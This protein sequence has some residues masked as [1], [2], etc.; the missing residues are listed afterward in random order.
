MQQISCPECKLIDQPVWHNWHIRSQYTIFE[1]NQKQKHH[2]PQPATLPNFIQCL[3][4][5][6]LIL[7][8]SFNWK[9]SEFVRKLHDKTAVK[10]K[11][12][13]WRDPDVQK[14]KLWLQ[15]NETED[16]IHASTA[17]SKYYLQ[18]DR[19]SIENDVLYRLFFDDAWKEKFHQKK[20]GKRSSSG[21]TKGLYFTGFTEHLI[22]AIKNCLTC[23]QLK[24]VPT[25]QLKRTL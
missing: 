2:M 22:S 17:L 14:V 24:K 11:T 6:A 21:S 13:Q 20:C 4:N 5:V 25:K 23:I 18:R 10:N 7:T 16:V 15:T 8:S 9:K 3:K 19:L 1:S 12:R